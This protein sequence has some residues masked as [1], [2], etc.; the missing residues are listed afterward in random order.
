MKLEDYLKI[1]G[2][3]LLVLPGW[4]TKRKILVIQSDD[5]GSIRMPSTSVFKHLL[6]KGI[7]VDSCPYTRNDSLE[8]EIDL[9]LMF[10][11]LLRFKD[12]NNNCPKITANCLMANPDFEKIK[13]DDFQRYHYE[14]VTDTMKK[15]HGCE[16]SFAYWKEGLEYK[17]FY[18]EFHGREHLD[19]SL[20]LD[21][22]QKQYDET[23][24]AF[25]LNVFGIS[26]KISS[27]DR[28]SFLSA[29]NYKSIQD[30]V[31]KISSIKDGISIFKKLLGY[32]PSSYIAAN[33]LW[34]DEVEEI[35]NNEG[36]KYIQSAIF[37]LKP[38]RDNGVARRYHFTGQRNFHGQLYLQR[39]CY[40]EPS[41]M[42]HKNTLKETLSEIEF[43]F[44]WGKP[45]IISSHRVNFIGS[46]N[47]EN[48]KTNLILF[49]QLIENVIKRWPDVEFLSTKELGDLLSN[50]I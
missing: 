25:D 35:I 26:K 13:N 10:N 32:S 11:V 22:L 34:F 50:G 16:N 20:W 15:Y 41:L 7:R 17:I 29:M 21:A 44:Y 43:A 33:Y 18:P 38:K 49:S 12:K 36:I 14:L 8:T 39:N 4:Q 6:S 2:K 31:Q 47:P 42:L 37:Q 28:D 45:A 5:W 48:R 19:V 27:E 23:K 46:I 24:V 1:I 9:D 40:F 30:K 3:R